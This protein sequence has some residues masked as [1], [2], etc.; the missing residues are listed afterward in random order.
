MSSNPT[1]FDLLVLGTADLAVLD[2]QPARGTA[3]TSSE[4][5]SSRTISSH[6]CR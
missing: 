6:A 4:R 5:G 3:D 2:E 1:E